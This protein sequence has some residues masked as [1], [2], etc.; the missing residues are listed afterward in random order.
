VSYL[1]KI[2]TVVQMLSIFLLLVGRVE[3]LFWAKWLAWVGYIGL[4]AAAIL[5]VWTMLLYLR[6]A[7]GEIL[8]AG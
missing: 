7:W 4:Y 5:T 1:A 2:K 3:T 6:A 8:K